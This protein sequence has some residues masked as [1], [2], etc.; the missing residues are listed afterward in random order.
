MPYEFAQDKHA[1]NL[2]GRYTSYLHYNN[3]TNNKNSYK[4]RNYK[5]NKINDNDNNS[6]G[7]NNNSNA[8]AIQNDINIK[9]KLLQYSINNLSL[10]ILIETKIIITKYESSFLFNRYK[11]KK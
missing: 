6:K 11:K 7:K 8:N 10:T 2:N 4:N 3:N 1:H 9:K 5:Y